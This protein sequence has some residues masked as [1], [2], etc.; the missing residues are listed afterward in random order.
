MKLTR[1]SY[2][3]PQS[4]VCL[5]VDGKLL[6]VQL[7]PGQPVELPADNDYTKVLLE[8]RH[9]VPEPVNTKPGKP[10]TGAKDEGGQTN[11]S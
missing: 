3:G 2:T 8:L 1:Y 11:G 7:Q 4:A 9:L 6:D 5:R 10:A